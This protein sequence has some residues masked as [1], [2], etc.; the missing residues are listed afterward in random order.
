MF[1]YIF[2]PSGILTMI[3]VRTLRKDIARYNRDDDIVSQLF[4]ADLSEFYDLKGKEKKNFKD[5]L[6]NTEGG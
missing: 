5:I 3:M 2:F 1:M 6:Y 4:A